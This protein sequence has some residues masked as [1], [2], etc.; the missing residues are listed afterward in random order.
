MALIL[1]V[2]LFTLTNTLRAA[3]PFVAGYDRFA[4]SK[5]ISSVTAGRLLLTELSCTACHQTDA[6][7]LTPKGGP[8]L[9]A[10]GSRVHSE[11][12]QDFL[13]A[14]HQMKQ[15]ITMPDVLA[16]LPYQQKEQVVAALTAFLMSNTQPYPEIK[17]GGASPVPF[18]FWLK[19][20]IEQGRELYH[21]RGCVA[22]HEPDAEYETVERKPTPLDQIIE[23]LDADEL[24]ELGL[25]QLIRPVN[26]VPHGRLSEKYNSRSLTFFLLNPEKA[27]PAGR[28]P[29]FQFEPMDA[30]HIA[31]YL[32]SGKTPEPKPTEVEASLVEKGKAFFVD[33]GCVNCHSIKGLKPAGQVKPLSE[34][35]ASAERSCLKGSDSLP[36]YSLSTRQIKSLTEV[37]AGRQYIRNEGPDAQLEFRLLQRNCY[38]CHERDQKGGVGRNRKAYFETVRHID[39]GDEGRIPPPLTGVGEKLT[40]SW[41]KKVLEGK[42]KVRPH[43]TARMPVFSGEEIQSLPAQF[44]TAD[45]FQQQTDREVF[46]Q[47]QG[48]E[49]AGRSLMGTGCVQCHPIQG[50]ALP[51]VVGVDLADV[52]D[53]IHPAWFKK[54]LFNPGEV[55]PRT[56]MPTFFPKGKSSNQQ[57]LDGDVDRQIA[58]LWAYLKDSANQKLPEKILEVRSR[59]YELIP[60]KRPLVLRTFMEEAGTHAIAVGFPQKL[61][62]AYDAEQIRLAEVWQGRFLD[63]RG[64]W[65]ERFTPPAVP[66]G[67]KRMNFPKGATLRLSDSKSTAAFRGYRLDKQGHPMFLLRLSP[68]DVEEQIDAENSDTIVRTWT[69]NASR[70]T[71]KPREVQLR[72][73][74]GDGVHHEGKTALVHPSG[75]KLTLK[76]AGNTEPTKTGWR[77]A[78]PALQPMETFSIEVTYQW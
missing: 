56:R 14:P 34:L 61:H 73:L 48:L 54:F 72:L 26:S 60:D 40:Q 24:K 15:G 4:A 27:R 38:G 12:L 50:E 59:N 49:S 19:G 70:P 31:A 17:A 3:E 33:L 58:A 77:V 9:S 35:D 52:T 20:N 39:L 68:W 11:W 23:Q 74:A 16:E 37:L 32:L 75:L 64:T 67:T 5:E 65:F 7:T 55:K 45:G 76:S 13:M 8:D 78:V 53:R 51:G 71:D 66:L 18:E 62:F 2:G 28:M 22:C 63:A 25:S 36:H 44:A 43:L 21:K 10:V 30:S 6:P 29:N 41:M 42:E 1:S 47:F 69:F 46:G 57:I